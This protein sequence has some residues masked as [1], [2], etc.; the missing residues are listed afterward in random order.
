MIEHWKY[1]LDNG[2][3][4]GTGAI[5][6]SKALDSLPHG[7]LIAKL[8]VYG[9]NLSS[10]RLLASY[11]H[12]RYQGVEIKDIRNDWLI[13]DRGVPQGSILGPL[14]FNVFINDI[15]FLNNDINKYMY[16]GDNCI[17]YAEKMFYK[18]K[19]FWK[20]RLTKWWTGSRKIHSQPTLPNF[21]QCSCVEIMRKWTIWI[22]LL[23][24]PSWN[25]HLV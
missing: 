18:S 2:N 22:S 3:I 24:I 21:R 8:H 11:L 1:E 9:V 23:K 15:F 13:M 4:I 10:C 6:L 17:S 16:V 20:R 12:N 5:D 19:L 25:Q 7:L 14:L